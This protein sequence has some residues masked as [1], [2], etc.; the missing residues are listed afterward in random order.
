MFPITVQSFRQYSSKTTE[1]D[2]SHV[3]SNALSTSK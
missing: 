2:G 1:S 3:L